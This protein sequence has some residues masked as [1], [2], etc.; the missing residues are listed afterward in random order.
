MVLVERD[1][2]LALLSHLLRGCPHDAG[3]VVVV[4]GPVAVGKTELLHT[5]CEKAAGAGIRF[6]GAA[7]PP[8]R[9]HQPFGLLGRLL[10]GARTPYAQRVD[11]AVTDTRRT[12]GRVELLVREAVARVFLDL[13]AAEP[14]LIGVDDVH[15]ADTESLQCLLHLARRLERSRIMLVLGDQD[16]TGSAHSELRNGLTP[17]VHCRQIRL[18]PLSRDGVVALLAHELDPRVAHRLAPGAFAAT[19]GNPLLVRALAEDWQA[20]AGSAGRE[21]PF[22]LVVADRFAERV[23]NCLH[24]LEPE[25]LALARAVAVRGEAPRT[26][27]EAAPA[28]T[29]GTGTRALTRLLEGSGLL[30]QGRYRHQAARAAV[31]GDLDSRDRAEPHRHTARTA[32]TVDDGTRRRAT[33]RAAGLSAAEHR[34]GSLAAQG[35]SNRQIAERL[36]ITVSTVEQ[37]LTQVYR[38]LQVKRRTDLPV[39]LRLEEARGPAFPR[40][41]VPQ[42]RQTVC[43]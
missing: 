22:S 29:G 34:V 20:S 9:R 27:R 6:L 38:K 23:V 5:F 17:H 13:S 40:S 36:C 16:R 18:G 24:R 12:D 43:R 7:V 11:A 21:P 14:L 41:A 19:G 32:H 25:A 4:S 2:Q 31:L 3:S 28:G 42:V 39:S 1:R 35:H 26:G 15:H 37:H 30:H 33:S 8:A 10:N